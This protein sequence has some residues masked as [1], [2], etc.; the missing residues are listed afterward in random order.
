MPEM[1]TT[2]VL[3]RSRE[4]EGAAHALRHAASA[5]ASTSP[6]DGGATWAAE[7]RGPRA[8]PAVRLAAPSARRT[9]RSTWSWRGAASA[10]RSAMPAT[11]R[12]TA[13][14]TAPST[15][16]ASRCLR[17][18]TART[19]WPWIRRTRSGC[20]S[21]PGAARPRAATRAAA[22]SSRP[23][24][25]KAWKPVLP[26]FQHVYDVTIDPRDPAVLYASGFD[27]SAFRSAD[28]GATWTRI[29]GFN[30]KWGQRVI[31]D[32]RDPA[33]IYVTTYGGGVWH[34]P[35]TGDP[36]RGRGRGAVRP[37]PQRSRPRRSAPAHV[38]FLPARRSDPCCAPGSDARLEALVEANIA[39]I[40]AYQIGAR[41]EGRQG[42]P[43]LLAADGAAR[44]RRSRPRRL[45]RRHSSK[46]DPAVVKAWAQGKPSTF[47]PAKDL[48]PLLASRPVAVGRNPAR[49]T[50]SP[51]YLA[52]AAQGRPR[53]QVR[54][55]ANLYQTVLEVERDGD[56][57]QELFALLH[58]PRPAR[59]RRPARPARDAT[60]DL[61]AVGRQL[62]GKSCASPVGL[63][64]AEW[65]IA[66]RKIW[67]W[68]EKNQHIRDAR[69]LAKELLAEPD[70]AALIPKMRGDA[71]AEGRGHRP[72]VHHGPPLVVAL[73]LRPH[74]HRDVRGRRTP[75]SSSGSSRA[76]GSP[77]R[78]PTRTS[79]R[80][81]WPGSRTSSCSWS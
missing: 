10:A 32:P 19:A 34:G 47:D 74:R 20:T 45:T 64:A 9:A 71:R 33:K 46:N 25:G 76:G 44:T 70:V 6:I 75:R 66:G 51:R 59:V 40:H 27:Q 65:Q 42:R 69:V 78:A 73:G 17:A 35:A 16:C 41:A 22:S 61:L 37:L 63:T 18:R 39:G 12:S 7:E 56:R 60:T 58:R 3:R 13:P 54:A 28:R 1:A 50:S 43:G 49:S 23:M 53:C 57:L 11:A 72:L 80:T 8:A 29:R 2:H 62:E 21:R 5:A 31:P 14:P 4:P 52:A 55:I 30:F 68:G 81:R 26:A 38:G 36:R 24:A 15:G 79:S 77:R 48:M 67:N